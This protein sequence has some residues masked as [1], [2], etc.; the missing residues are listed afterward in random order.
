[1]DWE[2]VEDMAA[3]DVDLSQEALDSVSW[4]ERR[5]WGWGILRAFRNPSNKYYKF[6]PRYGVRASAQLCV[7]ALWVLL[8]IPGCAGIALV[9]YHHLNRFIIGLG[10]F[11][12][13]LFICAVLFSFGRVFTAARTIRK[14]QKRGGG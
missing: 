7:G 14:R 3:S 12:V 2:G 5:L 8:G 1:M 11:G 9:Q 6:V 4:V 13:G 10:W